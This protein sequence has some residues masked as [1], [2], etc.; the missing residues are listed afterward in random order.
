MNDLSWLTVICLDEPRFF[1]ET[2][3]VEDGF[4]RSNEILGNFLVHSTVSYLQKCLLHKKNVQTAHM[5]KDFGI[6]EQYKHCCWSVQTICAQHEVRSLNTEDELFGKGASFAKGLFGASM[7]NV[8][9]IYIC[10][11]IYM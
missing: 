5:V 9:Y 1:K 2:R 8:V 4:L 10:R 3:I 6:G 7:S 11:Y